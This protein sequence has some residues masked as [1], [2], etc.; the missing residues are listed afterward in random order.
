MN[1]YQ[2]L[3]GEKWELVF[4]DEPSY[5]KALKMAPE[6]LE[7]ELSI[8][9]WL[10]VAFP[11]WSTPV[12]YSVLAAVAC[13]KDYGGKLQLGV[14]PFEAHGEIYK[15]WPG[16]HSPSPEKVWL[17]VENKPP[18]L[19]IHISTDPSSNPIWLLLRKGEAIHQGVGPRS[20]EE[21]NELIQGMR[22]IS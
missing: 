11:V 14:R 16:R 17:A 21:L 7:P 22:L 10:I 20:R 18:Q 12:R 6:S 13:A 8:G 9:I 1:G 19:E 5:I 3:K 2:P 15:W 4:Y